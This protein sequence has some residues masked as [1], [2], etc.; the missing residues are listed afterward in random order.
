MYK[1]Q[2]LD[3]DDI[4]DITDFDVVVWLRAEMRMMLEEELARAILV[5][6]GRSSASDDKIQ[7]TKIRPIAT[8]DDIYTIE[9]QLEESTTTAQL[10]DSII[11]GRKQYK[12]TGVPTFFTTPDISGDMLLLKDTTGRRLYNTESDLAAG[13]RA[14]EL[15]EVPVMENKVVVIT[16]ATSG[17]A[18]LQ[19]RLIGISVNMND[20]S[21]GADK[22]GSISM[23][24]DFDIDYNQFKY[25]IET[26]CS[27]ALT[28]PHS[29]IAY[30][31]LETIPA[32]D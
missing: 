12:G 20:Y 3:R 26:R 17:E 19:K 23:F 27:G 16:P 5:G 21:L 31:K 28:M 9:I 15:I 32:L 1:K 6:D 18:G 14:K 4:I 8:D 13:I 22:G 11:R 24:D 7:E 29:A 25:L 2:K 10:I 30:W